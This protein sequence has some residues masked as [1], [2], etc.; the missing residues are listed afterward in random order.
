MWP[1]W[2]APLA[3]GIIAFIRRPALE[4]VAMATEQ[5]RGRFDEGQP[6][7]SE[8]LMQTSRWKVDDS[9]PD[10]L[11]DEIRRR[12]VRLPEFSAKS[13]GS[14]PAGSINADTGTA[15]GNHRTLL[16]TPDGGMTLTPQGRAPTAF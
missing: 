13:S 5:R 3:H 7:R 14:S 6:W 15:V 8:V 9:R 16:R 4:T 10:V 12:S 1:P 2:F 11:A